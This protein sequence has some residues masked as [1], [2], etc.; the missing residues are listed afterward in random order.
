MKVLG[1]C[2]M[3]LR[4]AVVCGYFRNGKEIAWIDS[5]EVNEK[6]NPAQ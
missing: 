6:S 1:M 5:F 3:L 2:F 4:G